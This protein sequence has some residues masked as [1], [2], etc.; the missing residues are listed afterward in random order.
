MSQN[1]FLNNMSTVALNNLWNYIQSL[2][3]SRENMLWLEEKCHEA[4]KKEES[5]ID[6]MSFC[7]VWKD[8][9]SYTVDQLVEDIRLSRNARRDIIL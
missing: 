5:K 3:L 6:A 7:G 1:Y 4:T 2:A 8:G 9:E